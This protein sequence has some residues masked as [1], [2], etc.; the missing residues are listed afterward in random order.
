M[1]EINLDT[2]DGKAKLFDELMADKTVRRQVLRALSPK[3]PNVVVP[4][5]E[6]EDMITAATKP[7]QETID[8]L[9][10]DLEKKDF[11]NG[12]AQQKRDIKDK[13][14]L[15]D[16]DITEVEKIMTEK[17]IGDYGTAVEHMRLSKTSG[18]PTPSYRDSRTMQG[19]DKAGDFFKDPINTARNEAQKAVNEILR[20]NEAA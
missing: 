8:K 20:R 17:K 2:A 14:K 18:A 11:D 12:V 4:E 6:A 13:F 16:A 10:T 5:L 9:K 19:P 15:S 1:P 3:H 7:L